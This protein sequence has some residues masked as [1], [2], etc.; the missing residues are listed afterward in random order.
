MSLYPASIVCSRCDGL[1][2]Y[3]WSDRVACSCP[4]PAPEPE[5][6]IEERAMLV[7]GESLAA[8]AARRQRFFERGYQ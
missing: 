5:R 2:Q 1:L 6:S 7:L 3:A 8:H 4:P